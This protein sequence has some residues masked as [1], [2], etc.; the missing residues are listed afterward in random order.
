MAAALAPPTVAIITLGCKLNMADSERLREAF[1]GAGFVP[2]AADTAADAFVVNTCTVTHVADRKSRQLLRR[3]RR[4]NREAVVAAVGCY[5][6]VSPDEVRALPEVDLVL[7]TRDKMAVVE[8]VARRLARPAATLL[9][10]AAPVAARP[11]TRAMVK[12]EEGC[13]ARCTFCIIPRARGDL[14]SLPMDVVV[15]QVTALAAEHHEVV[16]TG[17]NVGR[18]GYE[19]DRRR[20]LPEL[21][22]RVLDETAVRRLRLTSIEPSDLTLELLALWRGEPR[23]ARHF[24][25]ALQA[26]N[27]RTLRAMRRRYNTAQFRRAVD[28]LRMAVPEV[29]IT[30]D[31]IGG[32][33]GETDE[34]HAAT[35]G[36]AREMAFSRIHVFPYSPRR[37]TPAAVRPEQVSDAVREQ[38]CAELR[39]LA[40]EAAGTYA[41]RWLG[42]TVEVLWEEAAPAAAGDRRWSGYTDTYVRVSAEAPEN[43]DLTGRVA[44]ARARRLAGDGLAGEIVWPEGRR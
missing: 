24:H 17:T 3:A 23:L 22:R 29:A 5:P 44:D 38:R 41:A 32:F 13:D 36:F 42:R 20:R 37:G 12:I 31:I 8:A 43:V 30:T 40:V 14:T 39:R 19:I 27:D 2:V 35:V 15:A 4:L 1:Q 26:G 6:A 21:L 33:P 28:R 9:D 10:A 7:G 34:D 18:Y 16:L 11:R 25:L